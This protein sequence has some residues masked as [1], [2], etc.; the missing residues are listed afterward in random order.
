MCQSALLSLLL[1]AI[2]T[3][4]IHFLFVLF[5]APFVDHIPQTLLCAAHLSIL[6]LFPVFYARGVDHNAL[7]ELAGASAPLDETFGALIGAVLG[8]W[9]GAIPIPLDWDR[10]WQ[11]WP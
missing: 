1:T 8:A 6:G 2:A 11:K 9:L 10:E 5:G 3:P 4:F 7:I